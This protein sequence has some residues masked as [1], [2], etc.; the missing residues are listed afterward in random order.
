MNVTQTSAKVGH[1]EVDFHHLIYEY[2][3]GSVKGHF[4]PVNS[5][6]FCP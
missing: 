5:V 4:G 1:F 2:Y 3:M 6:E